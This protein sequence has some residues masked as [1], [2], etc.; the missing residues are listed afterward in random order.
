MTNENID[1]IMARVIKNNNR[2]MR[3][4]PNKKNQTCETCIHNYN[5]QCCGGGTCS[6]A[7][8]K[9]IKKS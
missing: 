3:K 6:N 2:A 1:K 4:L 9:P 7:M 5:G 8:Y